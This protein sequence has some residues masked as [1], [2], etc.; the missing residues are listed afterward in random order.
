MLSN[1]VF[2]QTNA[3][4]DDLSFLLLLLQESIEYLKLSTKD[5]LYSS[6]E[7]MKKQLATAT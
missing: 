7:K 3:L 1:V 2:V 5:T 4:T 6:A